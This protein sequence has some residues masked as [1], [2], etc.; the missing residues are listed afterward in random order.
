MHSLIIQMVY[1]NL[2]Q[3]FAAHQCYIIKFHKFNHAIS[4]ALLGLY[5]F[6]QKR[7]V[8]DPYYI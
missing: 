1:F 6:S 7:A 4:Y 3:F 8:T 2:F 5:N